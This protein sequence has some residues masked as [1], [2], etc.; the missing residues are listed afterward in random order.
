M[1]DH[2]KIGKDHQW[3]PNET[4]NQQK[5][6]MNAPTL[7]TPGITWTKPPGMSAPLSGVSLL[8]FLCTV[9]DVVSTSDERSARQHVA[10][11]TTTVPLILIHE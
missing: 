8:T 1:K 5:I 3:N 4:K 6:G 11:T 10:T 2:S 9:E 7:N